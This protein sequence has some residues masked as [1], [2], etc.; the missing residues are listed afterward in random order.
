MRRKIIQTNLETVFFF[1]LADEA[2][3]TDSA[4]DGQLSVIIWYIENGTSN[5]RFVDFHVHQE[6]VSGNVIA[7]AILT[8]SMN[9]S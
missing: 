7:N 3:C 5:E 8:G 2:I 6:G 4:D 9:G 1:V